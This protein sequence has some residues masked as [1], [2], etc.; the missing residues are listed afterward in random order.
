M[1]H[2]SDRPLRE[3]AVRDQATA[4][5]AVFTVVRASSEYRAYRRRRRRASIARD[6][7]QSTRRCRGGPRPSRTASAALGHVGPRPAH[8][9]AHRRCQSPSSSLSRRTTSRQQAYLRGPRRRVGAHRQGARRMPRDGSAGPLRGRRSDPS[10]RRRCGPR[11]P[12][13]TPVRRPSR[14]TAAPSVAGRARRDTP[15]R[16][17]DRHRDVADVR[18]LLRPLRRAGPVPAGSPA[19]GRRSWPGPVRSGHAAAGAWGRLAAGVGT[20]RPLR[21]TPRSAGRAASAGRRRARPRS[22]APARRRRRAP[23]SRARRPLSSSANTSSRISTGSSPSSLRKQLVARPAAAR[24]RATTTHHGSRTPWRAGPSRA[25]GRRGAGRPGSRRD[26]A[27]RDGGR[28]PP[29][30]QVRDSPRPVTSAG[31]SNDGL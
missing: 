8:L 25:R 14:S 22:P 31:S 5:P 15:R 6:G 1:P 18:R 2:T 12:W 16:P 21:R 13:S 7:R 23:A 28:R 4:H 3:A 29:E 20:A 11:P 26:R 10:G 9:D 17:A 24:G 30:Q 19:S 27:P